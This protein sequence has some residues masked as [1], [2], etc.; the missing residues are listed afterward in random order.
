MN[1]TKNI[2]NFAVFSLKNELSYASQLTILRKGYE[3]KNPYP[4]CKICGKKEIMPPVVEIK[5]I[6]RINLL[7]FKFYVYICSSKFITNACFDC[8]V[9]NELRLVKLLIQLGLN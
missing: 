3:L 2:S 5:K 9:Q 1:A 6:Y 4:K 7:F 8:S